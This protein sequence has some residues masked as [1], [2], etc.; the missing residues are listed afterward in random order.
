MA[1]QRQALKARLC[2]TQTIEDELEEAR[3]YFNKHKW[4]IIDVT[5]RSVEETAAIIIQKYQDKKERS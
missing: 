4:P 2:D 1:Y 5:R 3:R